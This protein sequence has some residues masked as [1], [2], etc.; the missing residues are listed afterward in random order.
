MAYQN[1]L[2]F[3]Y[4]FV[5][6]SRERADRYSADAFDLAR[7]LSLLELLDNPHETFP[8]ILIAGTKGKGSVAAM[9]A[10]ACR[11]A[12]LKTGLYTS[13]HLVRFGERIQVDGTQ[14]PK[15]CVASLVDQLRPAADKVK[16]IT[17]Y[18]LITALAYMYFRAEGIDM[19]VFEVG[20]GGRLDAT[21]VLS[22]LLSVITHISFDHTEI[23]GDTL[24]KIAAE[25]A[26]IIKPG[27]PVIVAP[28]A[29]AARTTIA[30]IAAQRGAP[31]ISVSDRW[32]AAV[33]E[34]SSEYQTVIVSAASGSTPEELQFRLPLL[35]PHQVTNAMVAIAALAEVRERGVPITT[36]AIVNGLENVEWPGR[37]QRLADKPAVVVD[38]AHNRAS[39]SVLRET[40]DQHFPA[41]RMILVFGASSDK[42]VEGM[43]AELV[44]RA[45]LLIATQ[46]FHPRA[47]EPSEICKLITAT[48]VACEIRMPVSEAVR[49]AFK[50]T[51]GT[52][53]ILVTGSLFVVGE[54]L[55]AWP[56][57]EVVHSRA[58]VLKA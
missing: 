9:I 17:T 33:R 53:L 12:G 23:L 55:D 16:G 37:F 22:P 49:V 25:K 56:E 10:A 30:E 48:G 8:S 50:R 52:D 35:G 6:Y 31:L 39:A 29:E 26:G 24:E 20:L 57:L 41:S 40:V 54:V 2:D 47:L 58:G 1:A 14:I 32:I 28:Q 18:E 36:Q 7:M 51:S 38:A 27:T 46:A 11:A 15:E 44:P 43:L 5:D 42:D 34:F 19:G 21:N 45:D 13:P 4:S 3:I